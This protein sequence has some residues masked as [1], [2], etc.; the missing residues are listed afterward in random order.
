MAGARPWRPGAST[1]RGA[2]S[3]SPTEAPEY[4]ETG[5]PGSDDVWMAA[6]GPAV[7]RDGA[8]AHASGGCA[9]SAQVAASLLAALGEDGRAFSR[10]PG[11]REAAPPLAFIAPPK[12]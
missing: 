11:Q 2:P 10:L 8:T 3:S 9:H 7:Q 1:V 4:N 5:V 12:N 6:I